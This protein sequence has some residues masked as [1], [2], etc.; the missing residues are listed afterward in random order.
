MRSRLA[1]ALGAALL[2][3][4]AGAC[5]Q[6]GQPP[7]GPE[8]RRPPVVVST[9]PD[10]FAMLGEFRGP[11]RFRFDERISERTT[12]GT[13]DD[14][15]IVSPRTG[16]VRVRPGRRELTVEVDG[17]FLPGVVYR[18]TLL[19]VVS[20]LF[21][22]QLRDPFEIVFSTGGE[23][24]ESAVAGLAW[25]RVS[26]EGVESLEVLAIAQEDSAVHVAR[27]DSGGIYAFRYLPPG[28]YRLVAFEDRNRDQAVDA[29]EVQGTRSV[30]LSGP[31]TLLV[32]VG[33]LQPDTTPARL[34]ALQVLDSV[35]IVLEFDDYLNPAMPAQ[36]VDV[37]LEVRV[38]TTGVAVVADTL[39][40]G[41]PPTMSRLMH[42]R[43]YVSWVEQVRD[44]FAR[45]DSV[46][47]MAI[48]RVPVDEADTTAIPDVESELPTSRVAPPALPPMG[49]G[50]VPTA[51][52]RSPEGIE[53][54]TGP[55]GEPLPARRLVAIL[56]GVLVANVGYQV[57]VAGVTNFSDI[58]LGGGESALVREPPPPPD[59]ATADSLA[60]PDS[61]S[62]D[63]TGVSP[64]TT[65]VP[66]DTTA[67]PPDTTG[68][69]PDTTGVPP[70]TTGVPPDTT[71]VPP[72]T[73]VVPPDTTGIPPDTG[74][75]V[76]RFF[77]RA[78]KRR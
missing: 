37:T 53:E 15:V 22:N 18:V 70:D 10:T 28:R 24:I 9:E 39:D 13:M 69:P 58:P 46:E 26:G 66:A 1:M 23:L 43:E 7:G 45:L 34:T 54:P 29:M 3:G 25:D 68:V 30:L 6:Q 77:E 50:R 55:D 42:E 48:M 31:D 78:E 8:D 76:L 12:S 59:T 40:A 4:L 51:R 21:N 2:T 36:N 62:T 19:P 72:D 27:T 52:P 35:T 61:L 16:D 32:D 33:V 64:D 41:P 57:T 38:D 60:V 17:G 67:V 63:T 20:D 56:D 71:G 65:G 74:R 75:I 49:G 5:A 73:T 44:S 11:V 14:A 47:M